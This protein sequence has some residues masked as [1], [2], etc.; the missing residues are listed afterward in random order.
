[1]TVA[2]PSSP[3]SPLPG[4]SAPGPSDDVPCVPAPAPARGHV[5][6]GYEHVARCFAASLRRG[7]E[8]GAGFCAY[9]Q[10][11]LV[12]DLWGGVAD[13]DTGRPWRRDTRVVVF[14]VTKGLAAMA[15]HLLADRGD[16]DWDAP[17]AS[18]WPGFGAAGKASV[19]VRCLLN[20]RAG[21]AALDAPLT[22]DDVID[23]ARASVVVDALER[24][25]PAWSP[26]EDQAYH[27]ITWGLY[28][29]ELFRRVA[30]ES[31]GGFLRREI[32]APLGSDAHL[33]TSADL[34][35]LHATLY[36][37]STP[38]R[39]ANMFS[40]TVLAP[41]SPEAGIARNVV[42][43]DSM[44]R[45]VFSNPPT[46]RRGVLAYDDVAVRRAELPWASAT[47]SAHGLARAYLPFALGGEVDGRRYFSA[48]SVAPLA[49]RQSWSWCDG[50]LHKPVGWS[51]GF[52]KDERHLF[53]PQPASFGHAGMGGSLGWCDP[54]A[55]V[56]F[57]YLMNG[58][59]W[60]VRSPRALAL[61]R[62]LY[63]CA[64]LR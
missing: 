43:P 41:R 18:Y 39:V 56:A 52:L 23:P 33:G 20:H 22:M 53:C 11:R 31:L 25:T 3:S 17:V 58:M 5:A 4:P 47:S 34:D 48:A 42:S 59:D 49:T 19:T 21:L 40:T 46:G 9:V 2:T 13:R 37:P 26:G 57:G 8:V 29:G 44:A 38:R 24:Q 36:A 30:G 28:A 45:R 1:M 63:E 6:P 62:A 15:F 16:L 64:P 27:A 55:G 54:V 32:F 10:G 14:S 7:E 61:G 51:Q 35:P 60:R 50:V 12:V